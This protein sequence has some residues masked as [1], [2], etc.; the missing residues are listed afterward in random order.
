M[1]FI[2]LR[3]NP[4]INVFMGRVL[5]C[6][7]RE[8]HKSRI[9]SRTHWTFKATRSSSGSMK[10]SEVMLLSHIPRSISQD[11]RIGRWVCGGRC[12]TASGLVVFRPELGGRV[13]AGVQ[14][15]SGWMEGRRPKGQRVEWIFPQSREVEES[16]GRGA[17]ETVRS[18]RPR[19]S[20][21]PLTLL[22]L[23]LRQHPIISPPATG[24]FDSSSQLK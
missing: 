17:W 5:S 18:A 10:R 6:Y 24:V 3:I 4:F 14:G 13:E 9:Y 22:T 2:T 16:N 11:R 7:Q 12:W 21:S 20:I 23:L 15:G 1:T 8:N 19:T